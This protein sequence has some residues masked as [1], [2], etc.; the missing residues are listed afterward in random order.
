MGFC[1]CI[2][3]V[4]S[5]DT[6]YFGVTSVM[7]TTSGFSS[8]IVS[9]SSCS[10]L[11]SVSALVYSIFSFSRCGSFSVNFLFCLVSHCLGLLAISFAIYSWVGVCAVAGSCTIW[12]RLMPMFVSPAL[13]LAFSWSR[14]FFPSTLSFHIRSGDMYI[15]SQSSVYLSVFEAASITLLRL[16]VS[17]VAIISGGLSCWSRVAIRFK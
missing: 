9:C 7:I 3:V 11:V 10:L 6:L 17:R 2:V 12:F 15:L 16:S 5:G 8:V 13:L 1:K 14:S 4:I